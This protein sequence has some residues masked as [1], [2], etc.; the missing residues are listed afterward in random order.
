LFIKYLGVA[1][2]VLMADR[3]VYTERAPHNRTKESVMYNGN[4]TMAL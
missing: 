1:K 2:S 4:G 3:T